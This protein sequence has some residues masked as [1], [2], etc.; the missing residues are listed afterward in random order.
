MNLMGTLAPY[1]MIDSIPY[2]KVN[3]YILTKTYSVKIKEL[4]YLAEK[5]TNIIRMARGEGRKSILKEIVFKND[6]IFNWGIKGRHAF[7]DDSPISNLLEP[8]GLDRE[9]LRKLLDIYREDIQG[10]NARYFM[11]QGEKET[12]DI[13]NKLSDVIDNGNFDD[14]QYAKD[15]ICTTLHTAGN[16]DFKNYSALV[17][18]SCGEN[19]YKTASFFG[20][21]QSNFP[22][23][24]KNTTLKGKFVIFDYWDS[25][26]EEG[27]TFI[28]TKTLIAKMKKLGLPWYVDKHK[29]CM[30]RF[31]LYPQKMIGY[32][33]IEDDKVLYYE[34]NPN[35]MNAYK[36]NNHF[37][38]GDYVHIEQKDVYFPADNPY[39]RIY[40]YNGIEFKP[41]NKR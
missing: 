11:G 6:V 40:L 41:W 16:K 26:Y 14:L 15:W 30:V 21:S 25:I 1:N 5:N 24:N 17:S 8:D 10:R 38:I 31:A 18:T 7:I 3:N 22:K 29:E 9:S 2:I 34:F 37:L 28:R 36:T 33:Y 35:Y 23:Y 12:D 19:R 4:L 13:I 32:Y 27:N 39:R 20:N